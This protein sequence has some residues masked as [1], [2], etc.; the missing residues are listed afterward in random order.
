MSDE[1]GDYIDS[2]IK[3]KVNEVLLN[4]TLPDTNGFVE[5]DSFGEALEKLI[6]LHIRM[7]MIE[8]HIQTVYSDDTQVADLK[9]KLDICFKQKRP[10][11][12]QAMNKLVDLSIHHNKS[13]AEDSVK[14]YK[15]YK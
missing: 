15:D 9:R 5:T 6:I 10:K 3:E 13:L 11:L 4:K 7:W 8:D 2:K 14:V 12:V 1:I